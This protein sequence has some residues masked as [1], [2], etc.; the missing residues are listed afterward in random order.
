M[1]KWTSKEYI[2]VRNILIISGIIIG[3][4]LWIAIPSDIGSNSFLSSGYSVGSK[5]A[6]LPA[7]GLPLFVFIGRRKN[8]NLYTN[9]EDEINRTLEAIKKETAHDQ[10][11]YSIIVDIL[12]I[13]LMTFTLL[14]K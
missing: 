6:L 5:L 11:V 2:R 14:S 13:G 3:L 12:I 4:A 9:D 8:T 7:F 10:V 1:K